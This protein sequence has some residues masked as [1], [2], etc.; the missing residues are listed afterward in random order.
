MPKNIVVFSDGTGQDGGVRPEQTVS[1]VYKLYR[2]CHVGPENAVNPREQVAFYDPG[3]GTDI[4][5]TALTAP[6]R[7]VQKMLASVTGRGITTNIADCYEFIINHFESGDRK[8]PA[9]READVTE[10]ILSE[11]EKNQ[12]V[13]ID[14]I[15]KSIRSKDPLFPRERIREIAREM[16]VEGRRGRPRKNSAE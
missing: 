5:A 11:K 12:F 4:G 7:F 8:A 3:L 6:V 2:A 9:L 16:S 10:L 15:V 13:S 14:K 1:N